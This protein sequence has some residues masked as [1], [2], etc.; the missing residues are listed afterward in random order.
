MNDNHLIFI[1]EKTQQNPQEPTA[2]RT[3][4]TMLNNLL[5]YYDYCQNEEKE[6]VTMG[7]HDKHRDIS[8][9]FPSNSEFMKVQ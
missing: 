5:K 4:I 9:P 7:H 3:L 1:C 8:V 2:M 6:L